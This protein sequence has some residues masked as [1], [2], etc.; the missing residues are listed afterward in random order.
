MYNLTSHFFQYSVSALKERSLLTL[1]ELPALLQNRVVIIATAIF[2]GLAACFALYY[3][4]HYLRSN[5]SV[6]PSAGHEANQTSATKTNQAAAPLLNPG[7]D[8][9]KANLSTTSEPTAVPEQPSDLPKSQREAPL[10][11]ANDLEKTIGKGPEEGTQGEDRVSTDSVKQPAPQPQLEQQKE[12]SS[13]KIADTDSE[14]GDEENVDSEEEG[15]ASDDEVSSTGDQEDWMYED[16]SW[17]EEDIS[18]EIKSKKPASA[19]EKYYINGKECSLRTLKCVEK[20]E[21]FLSALGKEHGTA[22]DNGDC[23]WDSFAKS[24]GRLLGREVTIQ[25][26][27][28]RV[29]HE[30]KKLDQGPDEA[31]WVKHM[32]QKDR[33]APDTYE[34]YRDRVGLDCA[35]IL[36]RGLPAPIW[37]QESRDGAILCRF[38]Q[39][40]L[41][42]Y[43]VGYYDDDISKAADKDNYWTCEDEGQKYPSGESYPHNIE[44]ALYPGHFVPVRNKD[45]ITGAV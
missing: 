14:A 6:Q 8:P 28:E 27:R 41:I 16:N 20:L 29:S 39:V 26:L 36:A 25:E 24:L 3:C 18:D 17:M 2:A 1:K 42:V 33:Y 7:S 40:N 4:F 43:T 23:F 44:I 31:N 45:P 34:D 37:G 15:I 13:S 32:I 38:Y 21:E 19:K 10:M 30:V 22:I 5:K 12:A 11:K 35:E 9:S